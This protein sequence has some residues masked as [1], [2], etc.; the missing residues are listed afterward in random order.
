MGG[1][2]TILKSSQMANIVALAKAAVLLS[3]AVDALFKTALHKVLGVASVYSRSAFTGAAKAGGKVVSA[4]AHVSKAYAAGAELMV[5][6][7]R[8]HFIEALVM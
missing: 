2:L 6:E 1:A 4:A 5:S 8:A 7:M 3:A